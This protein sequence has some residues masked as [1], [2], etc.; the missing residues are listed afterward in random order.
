MGYVQMPSLPFSPNLLLL[1][2]CLLYEALQDDIILDNSLMPFLPAFQDSIFE[3]GT[4]Y[5]T[6]VLT[7]M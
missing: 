7:S 3:F 1:K 4:W 2:T 6:S 5:F